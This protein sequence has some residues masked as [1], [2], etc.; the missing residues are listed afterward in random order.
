MVGFSG[1]RIKGHQENWAVVEDHR[2]IMY[3]GNNWGVLEYDGVSWRLI[4]T[5]KETSVLSLDIDSTGTI[6]VGLENGFGYL[7]HD[8]LG[9]THFASLE[10]H[11]PEDA[12]QVTEV[13]K[14]HATSQGVYFLTISKLYLWANDSLSAIPITVSALSTVV[15]D[16]LYY[17]EWRQ[18]V[19]CMVE[20]KPQLV[21]GSEKFALVQN[22]LVIPHPEKQ[23]FLLGHREHGLLIYRGAEFRP[24]ESD[25]EEYVRE[26][27][28]YSAVN[29]PGNRL[30]LG[31]IRA[32]VV[33][34]D[35][36]GRLLHK[37]DKDS[38]LRDQTVVSMHY[39]RHG[40]LWLALVNG[41]ARVELSTPL[42]RFDAAMGVTSGINAL[43]RHKGDIYVGTNRGVSFLSGEATS[44]SQTT[45]NL[46]FQPVDGINSFAWALYSDGNS[47]L[48]GTDK[49]VYDIEGGRGFWV[50]GYPYRV[51]GLHR[52]QKQP[53]RL[54]AALQTG[55]GILQKEQ[56]RWTYI[57][58]V[59]GPGKETLTIAG[60]DTDTI[61]L[62]ELAADLVRVEAIEP[63]AEPDS[64]Y[65]YTARISRYN[66]EHGLPAGQ[67]NVFPIK[68]RMIFASVS[69]V[70]KFDELSKTFRSDSTYARRSLTSRCW[71][72]RERVV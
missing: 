9:Q 68:S 56:G 31:T 53:N 42:R 17:G 6:Y 44:K 72:R 12:T 38:G 1:R 48:A 34:I 64:L 29:L 59:Q 30:A 46:S 43:T 24:F 41:I 13:W 11:L 33:I 49:G 65:K 19:M 36:Q 61:W 28:L 4:Q 2:G 66:E 10:H 47:L 35:G 54:Y 32:G 71:P 62:A 21:P 22:Y 51:R 7:A 26:N 55:L 37:I 39:D 58:K 14:V 15:N 25:V 16:T 27:Q 20:G 57:G 60:D 5:E 63:M 50:D 8:S 45:T 23:T 67:R 70:Y 52:S 3:F 40:T 18:G 69:G